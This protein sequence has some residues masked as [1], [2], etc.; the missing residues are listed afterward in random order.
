MYESGGLN[1]IQIDDAGSGSLVGG[2]CIGILRTETMEYY[3]DIIPL[4]MYREKYFNKK[5][6]LKYTSS[7]VESGLKKI[8]FKNDEPIYICR[9]YMF[10]DT[11]ETL[12]NSGLNVISTKIEEPLQ[13]IIEKSFEGYAIS[14]GLPSDFL[15]YTKYPFHFHRLLR[16][17]YADYKNRITLCKTGWKSFEK[18]GH[19]KVETNYDTIYNS[20]YHCLKCGQRIAKYS[21]VKVLKY[22]SNMPNTI[23]LHRSC[24]EYHHS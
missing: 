15:K 14:L 6:Y 7:I 10:D 9:G 22:Y 24:P 21:P 13:S 5:Y 23:Y 2:T 17:V 11:R 1:L 3:Y 8:Q 4:K 12:K 19:L 16:W 18:Y 20:N